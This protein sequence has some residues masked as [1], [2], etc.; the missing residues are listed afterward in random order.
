MRTIKQEIRILGFDDAPFIPRSK[1]KA[2]VVGVIFKG[3]RDFDGMI[4]TEVEIDGLNA[5]DVIADVINKSKYKGEIRILM[6]KGVTIAGFNVVDI[7]KLNEKTGLPVIV[8]SR[9]MPNFDKIQTA[10]KHFKDFKQRWQAIKQAGEINKLKME[11]NKNIYYQFIGLRQEEAKQIILLTC[12]RSSIPEP[13][14]V[15]HMIA[16]AIVRGETGGRA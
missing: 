8:V 16:S 9:K 10:L 3:G 13:L 2:I 14:R 5:T 12:T 7:K 15:A 4:K 6:F 11:N 1:G